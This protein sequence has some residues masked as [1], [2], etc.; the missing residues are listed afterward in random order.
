MS[1]SKTISFIKKI[2]L[3]YK[4]LEPLEQKMAL[5]LLVIMLFVAI[6]DVLGLSTI[7]PFIKLVLEQ[8]GMQE[9]ILLQKNNPLKEYSKDEITYIYGGIAIFSLL[10]SFLAKSYLSYLTAKFTTGRESSLGVKLLSI[11]CQISIKDIEK[12]DSNEMSRKILSETNSAV[13]GFMLPMINTIANIVLVVFIGLF[14]VL[15]DP[16][17]TSVIFFIFLII[18]SSIFLFVRIKLMFLGN[19]KVSSN[20]ER[21]Q[22]V[23]DVFSNI[24][25]IKVSNLVEYFN[26]KFINS[27]EKYSQVLCFSHWLS[28]MPKY[29]IEFL[30]FGG[31][32]LFLLILKVNESNLI[33]IIPYI[34]IY[35]LAGYRLLPSA[36]QIFIGFSQ[37]EFHL[38]ALNQILNDLKLKK[39]I[40]KQEI[41]IDDLNYFKDSHDIVLD[42]ITFE[43]DEFHKPVLKKF[44]YK[45]EK[46]SF[47]GISG[48]SGSGKSTIVNILVGLYA[49]KSG[50]LR[51]GE[52]IIS[53]TNVQAWQKSIGYVPQEI[54]LLNGS[55]IENVAF[56]LE[57][58]TL[59]IDRVLE[60][61]KIV[62]IDSF[63]DIND[64]KALKKTIGE[65][66]N[67]LS[68]GQRQ[69]V[70]IARALYFQPSILILDEA[71]NGLD[72]NSE[73]EIMNKIS[74]YAKGRFSLVVIS[75]KE[76]TFSLVDKV[77]TLKK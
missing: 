36:N 60:V 63:I 56:G 33:Y 11:Y 22:I 71:T 15:M 41:N 53:S 25:Y 43:H 64:E 30:I 55:I 1:E 62:G 19:I 4:I 49:P 13:H 67:N 5:K 34:S 21:F 27:S 16:L 50:F 3:L 14:L 73:L 24:K 8:D 51:V 66:G 35:I 29:F 72:L 20:N 46:N 47:V 77:L 17:V 2:I 45:F 42:D 23:R 9:I 37:S 44:T 70:A 59:N 48:P 32:L 18:F 7:L 52:K 76:N 69:R 54:V 40:T 57:E 31:A 26:V 75:H 58:N 28:Q 38:P 12:F 65:N 6:I 68:G 61:S 39:R 10:L 74:S